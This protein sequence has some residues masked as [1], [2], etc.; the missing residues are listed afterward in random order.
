MSE[1]TELRADDLASMEVFAGCRVEDLMPLAELLQ[2]LRSAPGQALMRQGEPAVSFLLI[3]SGRVEVRHVGDDG[4][5]MLD[6]VAAGRIVG[7]MALLRDKPRTATVTTTETLTGWIGDTRAFACMAEIP[8][9]KDRLV[10]TARQRLAAFITPVPVRLKDHSELLLRPVLPGDSARASNG[11]VEFSSET[12][13]RRFMSAREPTPALMDYLFEV[14]YVDHFVWVIIDPAEAED[15]IVADAR[16]VR[17]ETDPT[18]AEIAFIVGDA[19][20]GKGLGTFLMKALAIAA[21]VDGV[22]KFSARVLSDNQSMRAILDGF[23]AFWK[24][25]D[26]GVVSTVIDVPDRS[27]VHLPR[28]LTEQIRGVAR[29][30]IEAVG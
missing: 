25:E 19:Y 9:V 30:V 6:E 11:P 26:L 4:V 2:P 14:D 18:H 21:R 12:L 17:D 8:G 20:Q 29:Q 1:L 24:R 15:N 13:Y 3:S 23:G 7:E 10:R 28:P 22:E 16:F 27:N 5:V